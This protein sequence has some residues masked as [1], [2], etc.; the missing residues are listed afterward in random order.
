MNYLIVGNSAA[1]VGAIEAIRAAD[2]DGRIT[3]LAAEPDHTYSRPLISYLLAGKVAGERMSYRPADFYEAHGVEAHLGEEVARVDPAARAVTTAAGHRFEYDRL[4]LATGGKPF[5]PPIAGLDTGGVFTFTQWDDVR[6]IESHLAEH[7]VRDAVVLG[8]GM[9][10]LK[11]A[12]ALM[13]RGLKVTIVELADRLLST[14]LDAEAGAILV[15]A[16]R[17]R[18]AAV[19]LQTTVD[20]VLSRG[21]MIQ[22]VHLTNDFEIY[23]QMLV[24]AIGVVPNVAFLAGSGIATRRGIVVDE[25][26]RTSAEDVYAAGDVVEADDVL[27]GEKR[28]IPILPLAYR[29][30]F[31]AGRNMA[32]LDEC[33]HGGMAMN[34]IEICDVPTIS[35]GR[36]TVCDNCSDEGCEVL[37]RRDAKQGIYKK[38][39]LREGRMVGVILVGEIDNA[40]I[41][42]GLIERQLNVEALKPLLLSSEFGLLSL[43]SEYRKHMVSGPGIEV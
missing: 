9:I 20:R 35:I 10:G 13:A 1:A 39:V 4:L 26:M 22:G 19:C 29:Q 41:F 7:A 12:E 42:A 30:G 34:S 37:V 14:T 25:R 23:C 36:T 24:V 33:Y 40:G 38:V 3:L 17:C 27:L 16:L 28:P 5:V 2:H 8:G 18:D 31:V 21:G 43:D 32:G 11:A 15:E 6:R